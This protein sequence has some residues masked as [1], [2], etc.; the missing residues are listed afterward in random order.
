MRKGGVDELGVRMDSSL[1][2]RCREGHSSPSEGQE[3]EERVWRGV[4]N[5]LLGWAAWLGCTVSCQVS[6]LYSLQIP[7]RVWL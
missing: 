3:V 2:W 6:G 5:E 4:N 7:Q 1:T